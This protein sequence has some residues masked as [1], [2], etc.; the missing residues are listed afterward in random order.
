MTVNPISYLTYEGDVPNGVNPRR[1]SLSDVGGATKIDD[2]E[3]PPAPWQASAAEYNEMGM[4]LVA[5]AKV[6]GSALL[7]VSN[8]GVALIAGLRAASSL[9]TIGAPPYTTTAGS[10]QQGDFLVVR[11]A[12]GIVTITAPA[13]KIIPPAMP[14]AVTQQIGDYRCAARVNLAGDGITISSFDGSG[15]AA[16][17]NFCLVWA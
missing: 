13:T 6:A 8:S 9:L 17:C 15:A 16:D 3:F 2:T 11:S 7:F 4:L 10:T 1:P 14:M 5:L 12:I